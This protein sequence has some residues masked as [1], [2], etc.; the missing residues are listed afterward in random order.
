MR[1]TAVARAN[2][3]G[4]FAPVAARLRQFGLRPVRHAG[5][6][7]DGRSR[8][9][10]MNLVATMSLFHRLNSPDMMPRCRT[11]GT[12]AHRTA[13]APHGCSLA[14]MDQALA[15]LAHDTSLA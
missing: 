5:E 7:S 4:P 11:A 3:R 12:T 9:V 15:W 13:T 10:G 6:A 8:R 1:P 2:Q 14:R